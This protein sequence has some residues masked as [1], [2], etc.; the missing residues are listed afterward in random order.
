MSNSSSYLSAASACAEHALNRSRIWK[1]LKQ[2]NEL[3]GCVEA[4]GG[5][6]SESKNIVDALEERVNAADAID[7]IR[8]DKIRD[9]SFTG[10][11]KIGAPPLPQRV[12]P[13]RTRTPKHRATRE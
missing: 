8:A 12:K 3:Y 1:F 9:E 5:D 6:I 11:E 13:K 2:M 4:E 10:P 7:E